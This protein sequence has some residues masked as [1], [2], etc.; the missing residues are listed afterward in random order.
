MSELKNRT[1]ELICEYGEVFCETVGVFSISAT[2]TTSFSTKSSATSAIHVARLAT[3]S[4]IILTRIL[5]KNGLEPVS[6]F[7]MAESELWQKKHI[8]FI[9]K[10]RIIVFS[11]SD[12]AVCDF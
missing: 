5:F 7:Y 8:F 10:R 2:A 1:C 3:A 6:A 12:S 9:E 4:T 11:R